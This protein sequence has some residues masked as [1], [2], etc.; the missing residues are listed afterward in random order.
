M[1]FAC[2][3]YTLSN[4]YSMI[5]RIPLG[6]TGEPVS[7]VGLGTMYFGS[8]VDE[9]ISFDLLDHYFE[10]GG[11][12][13][14]SAN[15]YASWIPG[16]EGGE[17]EKVLGKWMCKRLNRNELFITSKVGLPYGDVPRSLKC[18][19]I[20][21]ECEKSLNR[22][23]IETIDL[24][25]AHAYDP[26]TPIEETM[27]AFYRLKKDG[28]IR[29]AGASNFYAWQ[30]SEANVAASRSEWEG[31][32]CIQQRHTY[33]EPVARAN[34]GAQ[35]VLTPELEAFCLQK[36]L[37]IMAYSPLLGGAYERQDRPIP[38]HYHSVSN[39][40]RVER[41]KEV[42]KKLGQP[43][44]NVV[45]AWMVRSDP[46]VIPLLAGSSVTQLKMNLGAL[47]VHL[48]QD[49][50]ALLNQDIIPPEKY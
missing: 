42:A 43:L 50:M 19:L 37:G 7:C 1:D 20:I 11:R 38:A 31:F 46:P 12:L 15:K 49:Q 8:K 47:S 36:N 41:L 44:H 33:L 17:S 45:I 26:V 2:K 29:Y 10:Q 16:F 6:E 27:G 34:F 39:D 23:G 28:K 48:T 24:Y 32:V 35:L 21:S 9:R 40:V 14:D 18:D 13:L 25:F 4:H 22:L 30:I 3:R 5:C